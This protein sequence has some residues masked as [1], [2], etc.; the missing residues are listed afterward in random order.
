MLSTR[1]CPPTEFQHDVDAAPVGQLP[2]L[3]DKAFVCV[4]DAVVEPQRLQALELLVARGSGDHCR[5]SLRCELDGG[6]TDS[7]ASGMD[8]RRLPLLQARGSEEALLR[9]PDRNRDGRRDSGIEPIGDW[10]GHHGRHDPLLGVGAVCVQRHHLVADGGALDAG[11][12]LGHG[13]RTQIADDVRGALRRRDRAG[14]KI[15]ALD[16]DRLD[17][18]S[19]AAIGTHRIGDVLVAKHVRRAVL[20][21]HGGFHCVIVNPLLRQRQHD[22]EQPWGTTRKSSISSES[23]TDKSVTERLGPSIGRWR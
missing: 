1:F 19:H 23:L 13:A 4:V 10:P 8:Q 17:V 14:E 16:A 11:A 5:A 21:Y 20:E 12:N 15:A 9:G 22:D 3:L 6:H 7:A 2:N 18:N